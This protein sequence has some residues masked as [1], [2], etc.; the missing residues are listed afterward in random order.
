MEKR[1]TK[2][3]AQD[4]GGNTSKAFSGEGTSKAVL[5]TYSE[6]PKEFAGEIKKHLLP[7][8]EYTLADIGSFRGELLAQLVGQL[9]EYRFRSVAV[10]I[11]KEALAKNPSLHKIAADVGKLPFKDGEIDIE[12]VRAVLQWNSWEHQKNIIKEIART[13]KRFALIQ[14]AGSEN[15]NPDE[16][17]ERMDKLLSGEEI[18]KLKRAEHFFS[19]GEEIEQFMRESSINFERTKEKVIEGISDLYTERYG[20]S[21]EENI[22]AK[23]ILGGKDFFVQTNW[24]IFPSKG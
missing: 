19:S 8:Q 2:I 23:S 17:R 1:E 16:W 5:E 7:Q 18:P 10:D 11:N 9:P 21:V 12:I 24:T 4:M 13:V 14:H 15:Q 20:L 6:T 3:E 22:K